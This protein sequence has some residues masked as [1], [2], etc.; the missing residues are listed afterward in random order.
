LN[1]TPRHKYSAVTSAASYKVQ[2][3][4]NNWSV[5]AINGRKKQNRKLNT[6][7]KK[8]KSFERELSLLGSISPF[9]SS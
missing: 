5:S 2:R 3:E 4:G 1:D 7:E 8:S 9:T 6:F